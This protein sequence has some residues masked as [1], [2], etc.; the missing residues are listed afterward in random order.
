MTVYTVSK[1]LHVDA[2][3]S[4]VEVAGLITGR[5]GTIANRMREAVAMEGIMAAE[6]TTG[7]KGKTTVTANVLGTILNPNQKESK[8]VPS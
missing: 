2:F 7:G 1:R 3:L 5:S 4:F 8:S 6:L